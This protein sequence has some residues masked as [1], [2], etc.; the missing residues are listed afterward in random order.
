M[1]LIEGDNYQKTVLIPE[2]VNLKKLKWSPQIEPGSMER[3]IMGGWVNFKT[4]KNSN[5]KIGETEA[6]WLASSFL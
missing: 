5:V 3:I 1:P 6:S 4:L 2:R